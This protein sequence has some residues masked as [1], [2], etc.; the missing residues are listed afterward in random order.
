MIIRGE[1]GRFSGGGDSGAVIV[2]E[3]D[4]ALGLLFGGSPFFTVAN[5]MTNVEGALDVRVV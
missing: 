5:K 1:H 2:G 4:R 3:D